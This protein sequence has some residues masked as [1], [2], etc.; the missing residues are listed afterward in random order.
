V[1]VFVN[2]SPA[3]MAA[4]KSVVSNIPF[5]AR[6]SPQSGHSKWEVEWGFKAN[7]G[8]PAMGISMSL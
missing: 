6:K 3:D 5:L 4:A 1:S 8:L 7:S 2:L